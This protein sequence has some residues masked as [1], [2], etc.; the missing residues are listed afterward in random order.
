MTVLSKILHNITLPNTMKILLLLISVI[1]IYAQDL[2]DDW[3]DAEHYEDIRDE[4]EREEIQRNK[5][6]LDHLAEDATIKKTTQGK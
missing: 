5:E 4:S 1:L 6:I 2:S 3:Y